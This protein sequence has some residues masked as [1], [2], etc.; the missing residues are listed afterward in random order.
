VSDRTLVRAGTSV[1]FDEPRLA[2]DANATLLGGDAGRLINVTPSTAGAPA[3]PDRP[4]AS[5]TPAARII[6][7][8]DF[9]AAR[10]WQ[11]HAAIEHTFASRYVATA[12]YFYTAYDH[13][14]VF[15][16]VN[17]IDRFYAVRSIGSGSYRA[18]HVGIERR[19]TRGLALQFSYVLADLQDN[20]PAGNTGP[21]FWSMAAGDLRSDPLDL[22]RDRGP[23]ELDVRH[24]FRGSIVYNPAFSTGRPLVDRLVNG[25]TFGVVMQ[26]RSGFPFSLRTNADLNGDGLATNDRPLLAGRNDRRLPARYN[27]DVRYA[28]AVAVG[29]VR[30]EVMGEVRNVFNSSQTASVDAFVPVDATG[31]PLVELPDAAGEF[32]AT[33]GYLPRQ[34]WLGVRVSF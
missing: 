8:P 20:A 23:H 19:L 15:G 31:S 12:G 1:V 14:P 17:P 33:R 22:D 2:I 34:L 28:R 26:M 13:L 3:F 30:A 29:Q 7:D 5:L 9:V 18:L 27:V 11:S 24:D 16:I 6:A 10:A 4:A 25:N 21:F 32:R